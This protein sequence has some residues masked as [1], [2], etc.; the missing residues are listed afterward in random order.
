M[1]A[2][3]TTPR[4]HLLAPLFFSLPSGPPALFFLT[5]HLLLLFFLPW[6][7]LLWLL[8][9]LFS[10]WV[11]LWLRLLRPPPLLSCLPS[12][13]VRFRWWLLLFLL[14]LSLFPTSSSAS[15][16]RGASAGTSG[17]SLLLQSPLL[18]L[19]FLSFLCLGLL[20]PSLSASGPSLLLLHLVLRS[21]WLLLCSRLAVPSVP[22]TIHA[23][24]CR[25]SVYI[26]VFFGFSC[27]YSSSWLGL[28]PSVRSSLSHADNRL[29]S[30]LAS[31]CPASST[32]LHRLSRCPVHGDFSSSTAVPVFLPSVFPCCAVAIVFLGGASGVAF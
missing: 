11:L 29:V 20:L 10:L 26:A 8:L 21:R 24:I 6:L 25:F 30:L 12:P 19:V 28:V 23:Q 5:V 31:A 14:R 1:S 2:L 22:D 9:L 17:V 27:F 13:W 32:L 16:F 15:L 7:P 4:G 18:L 3:T